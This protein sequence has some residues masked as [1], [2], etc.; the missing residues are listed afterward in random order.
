MK[1]T[2]GDK[3]RV[4]LEEKEMS[5][6]ELSRKS[7]LSQALISQ[8]LSDKFEPKSDKIFIMAEALNVS[9]AYLLGKNEEEINVSSEIQKFNSVFEIALKRKKLRELLTKAKDLNDEELNSI[10][11]HVNGIIQ[12]KKTN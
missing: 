3:L 11:I 10:L 9:G 2:F 6:A 5:A 4:I 7:G 12:S 1:T 8:Y